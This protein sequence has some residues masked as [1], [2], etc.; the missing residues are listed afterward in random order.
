MKGYYL[1][2][3]PGLNGT[4][5]ALWSRGWIL[6]DWGDIYS[7]RPLWLDKGY[8]IGNYLESISKRAHYIFTEYPSY[9]DSTGGR[10][11]AKR[12]DLLKLTWFV[13][14]ICGRF[15]SKYPTLVTVQSW[16]GQLPK[17]VTE[18]RARRELPQLRK[19]NMKSHVFDAIGIGL[20][21]K[22]KG[23]IS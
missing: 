18:A 15:K 2:I 14:Y 7:K 13:G 11:V 19:M 5:W 8:E 20:Y 1:T 3:D 10:M 9:F 22:N 6:L 12:G 23:K 16:K 4:G 17:K 21:L